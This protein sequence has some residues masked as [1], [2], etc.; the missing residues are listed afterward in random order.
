MPILEAVEAI[1][2]RQKMLFVQKVIDYFDAD[3]HG[4]RLLFGDLSF[5][6]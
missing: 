4:K 2:L 3:L 1:N 6:T 5:K